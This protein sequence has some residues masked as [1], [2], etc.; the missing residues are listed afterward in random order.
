M[1]VKVAKKQKPYLLAT[2]ASNLNEVKSAV[3]IG[4]KVNRQMILMQ[5]NTNYTASLEN[6]R[7]INLNVLKTYSEL[8]DDLVLGLSD[9][10]PGHSTVLGAIALGAR[11]IEKHFTDDCNRDGPDHKF[12]MDPDTWR[13][14]VER[15][16]ELELALGDGKKA[17]E[18]NEND[19]VI[20][21]RRSICASKNLKAG[22]TL[23]REDFIMLRPAPEK[24]FRPYEADK[25]V[26]R[27]LKSD[28][29]KGEVIAF[30]DVA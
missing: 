27:Q 8:F 7:Y 20:V 16:R 6:F 18:E 11:A 24:S 25:L 13:E 23:Y 1:I 29:E 3:E 4:L 15:A 19:T 26:G 5:C 2:G 21:Q 28:K 12:S 10:T 22:S 14:M 17:V 9:H 30:D